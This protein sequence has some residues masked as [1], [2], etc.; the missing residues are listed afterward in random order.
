MASRFFGI[1]N[2]LDGMTRDEAARQAGMTLHD[3]QRQSHPSV[4]RLVSDRLV[5]W[6]T[7]SDKA[8]EINDCMT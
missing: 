5:C 1:A 8:F 4:S 6:D 3:Q 7:A 2:I